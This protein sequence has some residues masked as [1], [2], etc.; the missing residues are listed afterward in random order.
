MTRL[1]EDGYGTVLTE[2]GGD[3]S[4]VRACLLYDFAVSIGGRICGPNMDFC[5]FVA[6][7][8]VF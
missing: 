4:G 2:G 3:R 8:R 5:T 1:P 7:V 6:S